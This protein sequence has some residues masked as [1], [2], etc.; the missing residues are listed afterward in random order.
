MLDNMRPAVARASLTVPQPTH[1]IE[2]ELDTSPHPED[3]PPASVPEVKAADNYDDMPSDSERPNTF[4]RLL[5]TYWR[6][7]LWTLP[8]TAL[9]LLALVF[10]VPAS[11]YKLLGLFI[12]KPFSVTV[13]DSTTNTPV[14]GA[15]VK[16]AGQ[17][18][19]TDSKGRVNI[20][21][22]VGNQTLSVSKTYYRSLSQTVLVNLTGSNSLNV[23]LV[24]TGRQVPVKVVNKITGHPIPEAVLTFGDTNAKTDL[25]GQAT[26]VLPTSSQ[27]QDVTLTVDGYNNLS[28][29]VQVTTETVAAN[30]FAMVP[31]GHIYFLSNLSGKLDVVSTNLDGSN[32]ETVLAGTGTEDK[33]NTVLLASR[34]W[35]YLALL[36][37]RDGSDLPKLYL[38]NTVNGQ[39]STID[40]TAGN[41]TLL[42]WN[43]HYF[44][45]VL[46][47][48]NVQTWQPG[49]QTVVSYNAD[50]A[51]STTLVTSQATGTSVSDAQY[52]T[53][54]DETFLGSN[55]ILAATWY[56]YPGN[57]SVPGQQNTLM[58]YKLD[59][60]GS[61]TLKSVDAGTL[62][63]SN[64]DLADPSDIYFGVYGASSNYYRLDSNQNITQSSTITADSVSQTY[65]VYLLSPS[66]KNTFWFSVRDGKNTLFIGDPNG[67]N[68]SQIAS[69]SDYVPYGWYTD[70]Y[71]LVEKGGSE[72]Y[73][74]PAGG[75]SAGTPL[76]VSDYF[77][78]D[79]AI[80]GY[81]GGYGG[82]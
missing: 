55:L 69:L 12:T 63:I 31:K 50:T 18:A 75:F 11:R 26:V 24:A 49:A 25:N 32:R 45:Y 48:P 14:T 9:V 47:H 67:Q 65:P 34:D 51:K 44:A 29:K 78:P 42:G 66:G 61:K 16:L 62:Y 64:V 39:L 53:F 82:F 77:K 7:K 74:L 71:L 40:S 8:L 35:Q 41:Y 76:K 28:A 68:S 79:Y 19:T 27:T 22:P 30:T 37:K 43:N 2:P 54:S 73:I 59:G 80:Y 38:I 36:S 33:N 72:L 13:T 21:S 58:S 6:W 20:T 4:K 5:R 52:Q 46:G 57:I 17:T 10:A 15:T 3:E 70:D 56:V 23:Q 60:T 1:P 81:G